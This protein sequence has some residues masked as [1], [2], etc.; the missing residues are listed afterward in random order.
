LALAALLVAASS[1]GAC[2][3]LDRDAVQ[4][5]V[6]QVA[7][8]AAEGMLVAREAHRERTYVSFTE[9]RSGELHKAA[10][11]S[12]ESLGSGTAETSELQRDAE[13][14]SRLAAG[15]RR[16][17]GSLHERPSDAALAGRVEGKL[18]TLASEAQDLE[19]QL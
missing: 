4:T 15:V 6:E 16:A 7:S 3:E 12:E 10:Q 1:L 18:R 9:L 5:Q 14:G 13:A 2:G 17:L 11:R 8:A 19:E